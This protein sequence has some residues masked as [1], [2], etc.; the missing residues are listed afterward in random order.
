MRLK[1]PG[2]IVKS[3]AGP[4]W[5]DQRMG[6]RI[7]VKAGLLDNRKIVP[8]ELSRPTRPR[9]ATRA[10][11]PRLTPWPREAAERSSPRAAKR[12]PIT[13]SANANKAFIKRQHGKMAMRC[14][15][16]EGTLG[17][18][19]AV[20]PQPP[21]PCE[22]ALSVA[23]HQDSRG[24]SGDR[25]EFVG[26][27]PLARAEMCRKV[28]SC[29][30]SPITFGSSTIRSACSAAIRAGWSRSCGSPPGKLIIHSTGPFTDGRCDGNQGVGK[31]GLAGR[32]DAASRYL[33]QGRARGVSRHPVPCAGRLSR[34]GNDWGRRRCCPRRSNGG[35]TSASCA[36]R[37]CR[38][39][40]STS[41]CTRRR[42]R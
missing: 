38:R 23:S 15:P 27:L 1:N 30:R 6:T 17:V 8:P 34:R 40:R 12:P 19:R 18:R 11:C 31:A 7:K 14:Q 24:Y 20:E 41:S 26:V 37:G 3:G 28:A 9:E 33:R 42:G 2:S 10:C 35:R 32:F 16:G 13:K 4:T 36:S 21:A 25:P 29:S 39:L 22:H 5:L